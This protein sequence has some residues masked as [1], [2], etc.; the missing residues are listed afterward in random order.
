MSQIAI[1]V[2]IS[3]LLGGCFAKIHELP[4]QPESGKGLFAPLP[5]QD[6]MVGLAV[7]VA[8]LWDRLAAMGIGF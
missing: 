7:S 6:F 5:E 3:L 8:L 1:V 4:S 2:G